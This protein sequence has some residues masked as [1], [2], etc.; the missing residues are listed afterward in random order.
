MGTWRLA[1]AKAQSDTAVVEKDGLRSKIVIDLP[2]AARLSFAV[3]SLM[4]NFN[5]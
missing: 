4:G 3:L 1:Y 2:F 5:I